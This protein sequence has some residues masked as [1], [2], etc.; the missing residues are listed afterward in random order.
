MPAMLLLP[1][2]TDISAKEQRYD[3]S[4]QPLTKKRASAHREQRI[5][6]NKQN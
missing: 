5:K 6:G 2:P 4:D 3:S 1:H